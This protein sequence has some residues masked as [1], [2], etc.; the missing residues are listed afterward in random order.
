MDPH[1][2]NL[3]DQ[4][5]GVNYFLINGLR[6]ILGVYCGGVDSVV[7]LALLWHIEADLFIIIIIHLLLPLE[8]VVIYVLVHFVL[9]LIWVRANLTRFLQFIRGYTSWWWQTGAIMLHLRGLHLIIDLRIHIQIG[10]ITVL[11][12]LVSL[13]LYILHE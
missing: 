13:F 12:L 6:H 5:F 8:I 1:L 4:F 3:V 7:V 9:L 2:L 10:E 11:L